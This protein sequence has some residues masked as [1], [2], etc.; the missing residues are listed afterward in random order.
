MKR[1]DW[2]RRVRDV[3]D[4]ASRSA[5]FRELAALS[6]RMERLP[7]TL[8]N[9]LTIATPRG[10]R[11]L[12]CSERRY[13]EAL[14]AATQGEFDGV[15]ASSN[16]W[17]DVIGVSGRSVRRFRSRFERLGLI[18]VRKDY[19]EGPW[20]APA[21]G[22]RPSKLLRKRR[23]PNIIVWSAAGRKRHA[24]WRFAARSLTCPTPPRTKRPGDGES[25][26]ISPKGLGAS[27]S[28]LA[29]LISCAPPDPAE[30]S[31]PTA[32]QIDQIEF[33]RAARAF[34]A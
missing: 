19:E 31:R 25:I 24:A 33:R 16:E 13:L 1:R 26:Q 23:A 29:P 28:A 11:R 9:A 32:E 22:S 30:R 17:G 8:L 7:S 2:F 5:G 4:L 10:Q 21:R 3:K 6:V 34:L 18:E 12:R 14:S 15:Q 20:M 27:A